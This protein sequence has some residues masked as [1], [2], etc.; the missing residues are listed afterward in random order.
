M[1]G[2]EQAGGALPACDR[3]PAA[4]CRRIGRILILAGTSF[5]EATNY[6]A[7]ALSRDW[8]AVQAAWSQHAIPGDDAAPLIARELLHGP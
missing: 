5:R 4:G 7:A 3:R 2:G 1:V 8:L 6:S